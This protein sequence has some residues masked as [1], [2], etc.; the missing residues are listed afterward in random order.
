MKVDFTLKVLPD[1]HLLEEIVT[2]YFDIHM[3]SK[4][5]FAVYAKLFSLIHLSITTS[6]F[7]SAKFFS[8]VVTFQILFDFA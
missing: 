6:T 2:G 3:H 7:S 4:I 5:Q 1:L 8:I